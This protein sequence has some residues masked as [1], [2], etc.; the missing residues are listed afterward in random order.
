[1]PTRKKTIIERVLST[2]MSSEAERYLFLVRSVAE[3]ETIIEQKDEQYQKLEELYQELYNK[4][5][6]APPPTPTHDCEK[7]KEAC[8]APIGTLQAPLPDATKPLE[9]NDP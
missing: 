4:T 6:S 1:M 3:L 9:V 8:D 5:A 2:V 7:C